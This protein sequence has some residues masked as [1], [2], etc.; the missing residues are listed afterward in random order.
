MNFAKL[1]KHDAEE[2]KKVQARVYGIAHSVASN[3]CKTLTSN[4]LNDIAESTY[5]AAMEKIHEIY[6]GKFWAWI[7]GTAWKMAKARVKKLEGKKNIEGKSDS[8]EEKVEKFGEAGEPVIKGSQMTEMER[9]ERIR[10]CAELFALAK[11]QDYELLFDEM[12]NGLKGWEL[13]EKYGWPDG[14]SNA[15]NRCTQA[16]KRV[17][18]DFAS[19]PRAAKILAE[20]E[21]ETPTS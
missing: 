8:I 13:A 20:L 14:A 4:D 10:L 15:S 12:V 17:L 11:P 7:S 18:K 3:A 21:I 16:R 19:D 2:W 5:I 9:A 6:P 1:L